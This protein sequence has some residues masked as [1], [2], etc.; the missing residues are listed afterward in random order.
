M[1]N[2]HFKVQ[3]ADSQMITTRKNFRLVCRQPL[4]VDIGS[5]TTLQ[6]LNQY[7]IVLEHDNAVLPTDR[8]ALGPQLAR[9][10]AADKKLFAR[11]TN[12][13]TLVAPTKDL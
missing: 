11:H 5:V 6:V 9:L 2:H 13:A 7:P 1:L 10:T 3:L 12:F 8:L 4:V